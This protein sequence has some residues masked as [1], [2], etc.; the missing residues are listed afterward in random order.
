MISSTRAASPLAE[1]PTVT[2]ASAGRGSRAS[3]VQ[4]RVAADAE[5][6]EHRALEPE[7]AQDVERVEAEAD[8]AEVLASSGERPWPR[9]SRTTVR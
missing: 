3:S 4:E 2:S 7:G 1:A 6:D 8:D 5:A 9:R